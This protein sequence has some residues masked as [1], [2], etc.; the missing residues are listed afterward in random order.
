MNPKKTI[1]KKGHVGLP[2]VAAEVQMTEAEGH[3]NTSLSAGSSS[4]E[5]LGTR[6]RSNTGSSQTDMGYDLDI[7]GDG[8]GKKAEDK[9]M[10]QDTEYHHLGT[11]SVGFGEKCPPT[12]RGTVAWLFDAIAESNRGGS[13]E[14][15]SEEERLRDLESLRKISDAEIDEMFGGHATIAGCN[16]AYETEIE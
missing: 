6:S 5:S 7:L 11:A 1:N 8:E 14:P 16:Q 9:S 15:I 13:P 10:Q 12:D 3:E 4:P 2:V